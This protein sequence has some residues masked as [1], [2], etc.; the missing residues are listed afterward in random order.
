MAGTFLVMMIETGLAY[1]QANRLGVLRLQTMLE[2]GC[3]A[4]ANARLVLAEISELS[5]R[6]PQS[7]E[8]ASS[9]SYGDLR[10]IIREQARKI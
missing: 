3:A 6:S 8:P 1:L 10:S 7:D 5:S 9:E 2:G 4:Q